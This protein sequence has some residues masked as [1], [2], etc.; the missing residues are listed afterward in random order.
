MKFKPGD[1]VKFL[2]ASGG[3]IV[4]KIINSG[5]VNVAIEDGFDIP[6]SISDLILVN[7]DTA[8]SRFFDEDFMSA[9]A[10]GAKTKQKGKPE[11]RQEIPLPTIPDETDFGMNRVSALP[12]SR[13][14]GANEEGV[15]IA[16]VPHDQKWL[17]TGMLDIYLVNL[18]DYDVLY[19]YFAKSGKGGY[20]G[21]D[22]GSVPPYSRILIETIEREEIELHADGLVQLMFHKDEIRQILV[23]V[24]AEFRIKPLRFAKED[25]YRDFAFLPEKGFVYLLS[26]L[27]GLKPVHEQDTM[28]KYELEK[29]E[30]KEAKQIMP[31]SFISRHKTSPREA[32]VDLH[33]EAMVEDHAKLEQH[34]MLSLQLSYFTKCLEGAI[35]EN[36]YK[37]TFIHGVGNGV[38]KIALRERLKDYKNVLYQPAPMARFGIGAIDVTIMH[39]KPLID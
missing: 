11:P 32:I 38:L 13:S 7:T 1:R 15:Y 30:M 34:E 36:Y 6:T 26:S 4:T 37:V 39:E 2:N 5:I 29:P 17:I 10:S 33:I 31:E 21:M 24:S 19:S 9:P 22:Y 35:A 8:A 12:G 27:T 3:G 23:P 16:F 28:R 25:N 14:R 18:T 20:G